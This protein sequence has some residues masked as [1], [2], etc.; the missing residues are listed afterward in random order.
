MFLIT[1]SFTFKRIKNV[2]HCFYL[3]IKRGIKC[4]KLNERN[5]KFEDVI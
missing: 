3:L 5:G 2:T 4:L 1:S